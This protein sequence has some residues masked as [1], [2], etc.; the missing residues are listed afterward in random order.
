MTSNLLKANTRYYRLSY[1]DDPSTTIV[2]G[3]SANGTSTNAK[4]YY[5][6]SDM[7][8]NWA[9]YP[10][11]HSIDTT[12][13]YVGLTNNFARITGLTPN[14]KY[15]F[16][17]KDDQSTSARYSFKTIS[18]NPNDD[19]TFIS[20]GDS[21]TNIPI[22]ESCTD[23]NCRLQRQNGN[24]LVA[25]TRPNF[26]AFSGDFTFGN[27]FGTANSLWSDWL[28]D[29]QLTI[30]PDADGGLMIPLIGC[31][32]N[33]ELNN[34]LWCIF[35]ITNSNNYYALSFGGN[36]F[37]FYTLMPTDGGDVC[38]DAAQLNWF[39]NDLANYTGTS[40]EPYWKML[41]YHTPMVPHAETAP[42]QSMI[43]CWASLFQANNVSVCF[44]G[45]SHVLKYTWPVV[46][47]SAAG[48]DNGFI[49]DD[50]NGTVYVGE[51]CWGAPLRTLYTYY[52]A[53]QAYNWTRNQA[54]TEGFHLVCVS[55]T[56][57]EIR[58]IKFDAVASVGQVTSSDP[59]CT[60]PTGISVWTPSNGAVVEIL[61]PAANITDP[62]NSIKK[63][64]VFP[65]PT[66]NFVTLTVKQK[67][68][69]ATI[70]I[71]NGMG[72]LLKVVACDI[73]GDYKLSMENLPK[74]TYFIFIEAEGFSESHKVILE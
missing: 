47:S 16:V 28:T 56:K 5:G 6:T 24:K 41:Q 30:G 53:N 49:R 52:N 42:N 68:P 7:G 8:I 66:S 72:K 19:I 13:S 58:T 59:A 54:A 29:W 64:T 1:R 65:N 43:D 11:N 32:G 48:S 73:E 9:S 74:G 57:I 62:L 55:K 2:I 3:W 35:D 45:H 14:T 46:P 34:D 21:R 33:H 50:V 25:K 17:V 31:F 44:E 60:L 71:Y 27:Y 70:D 23:G 67:I 36:L 51:G 39:T 61:N 69:K 37:R 63:I 15:Y 4:V 26:V 20:G 12:T 10:L 38:A 22:F 18:D 40:S